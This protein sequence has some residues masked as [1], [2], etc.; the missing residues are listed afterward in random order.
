LCP[1][2][3]SYLGLDLEPGMN[4]DVVLDD[5]YSFPL[6]DASVEIVLC[7][8]VFEHCDFFWR[9]FE[10]A[11]RVLKPGGLLYVNA[12][13]NGYVHRYPADCWRF[14]PDSGMAL[15]AWGQHAGQ[16]V[17]LLE[18]FITD[19]D[20]SQNPDEIWNDFVAVFVNGACEADRYPHR[21]T[22]LRHDYTNARRPGHT[23]LIEPHLFPGRP[24]QDIPRQLRG[25]K[26]GLRSVFLYQ[27]AY[28]EETWNSVPKEMLPLDNRLNERPDWTEYWP[29]RRFLQHE[30]LDENAFYGFLSPRFG[31]KLHAS[32]EAIK[33][34]VSSVGDDIDVAAFSPY[35]DHRAL[36]RNVFEQGEFFFPGLMDISRQVIKQTFPEVDL[37]QLV[38]TSESAIFCNY[39]AAKPRFWRE[40][41]IRC[42]SV[43]AVAESN[44]HPCSMALNRGYKWRAGLIPAKVFLIERMA[45]LLLATSSDFKVKKYAK[46]SLATEFTYLPYSLFATLDLL[47]RESLNQTS[48]LLDAFTKIQERILTGKEAR[49]LRSFW[50]T[51]HYALGLGHAA[52]P[53]FEHWQDPLEMVESKSEHVGVGWLLRRLMR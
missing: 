5:P 27:I 15:M 11:L 25:L 20:L 46:S 42:E 18:S 53:G 47:K 35:F 3:L 49:E 32:P 37:L 9:L 8:S 48:M 41:L 26:S 6:N 29:I 36:F 23:E 45:S 22:D 51:E 21:M 24:Q 1:S 33:E 43:F 13:A 38:N 52:S 40:W 10:E 50:L 17:A 12:P 16:D 2:H 28:S 19:Q 44:N 31:E 39:F 4:V 30:T 7:S 34:F 14:Y